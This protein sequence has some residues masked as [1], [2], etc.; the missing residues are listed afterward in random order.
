MMYQ[1]IHLSNYSSNASNNT[2]ILLNI[3]KYLL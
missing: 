1:N 3:I 2:N